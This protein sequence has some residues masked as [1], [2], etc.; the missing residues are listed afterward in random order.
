MWGGRVAEPPLKRFFYFSSIMEHFGAL[1]LLTSRSPLSFFLS[2][3]NVFLF[4][5]FCVVLSPSLCSLYLSVPLFSS[6]LSLFPYSLSS[7]PFPFPLPLSSSH[8][9]FP[10]PPFLFPFPFFLFSN[11]FP[12]TQMKQTDRKI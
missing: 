2:I 12:Q 7:S 8:F 1:K 3:S 10:L 11:F 9:T 4:R 5:F 6:L